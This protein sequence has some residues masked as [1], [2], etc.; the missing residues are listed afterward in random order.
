VENHRPGSTDEQLE[1]HSLP[2]INMAGKEAVDE[3]E[4]K[5]EEGSS[6]RNADGNPHRDE[7]EGDPANPKR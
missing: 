1:H 5:D 3:C 7:K 4:C 2:G 6:Q